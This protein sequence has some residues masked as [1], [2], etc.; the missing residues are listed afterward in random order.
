MQAPI[1]PF[2]P[3][4]LKAAD[5][6]QTIEDY[7]HCA[8]LARDAGVCVCVLVCVT[9]CV[10]TLRCQELLSYAAVPRVAIL[11]LPILI[12]VSYVLTYSHTFRNLVSE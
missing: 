6:W 12:Y 4:A 5:V 2:K 9:P 1:A 8:A 7:V 3:S 10:D 11:R